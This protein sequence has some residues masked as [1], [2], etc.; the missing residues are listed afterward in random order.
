M[1]EAGSGSPALP[2]KAS[3]RMGRNTPDSAVLVAGSLGK[4]A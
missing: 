4:A 2:E 1:R 3:S